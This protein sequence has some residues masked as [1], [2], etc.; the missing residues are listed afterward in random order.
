MDGQKISKLLRINMNHSSNIQGMNGFTEINII[1]HVDLCTVRH[2][3]VEHQ[4]YDKK[5]TNWGQID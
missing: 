4:A 1:R 3:Q 2:L 5:N